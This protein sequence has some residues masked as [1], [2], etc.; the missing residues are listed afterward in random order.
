MTPLALTFPLVFAATA[1]G[2]RIALGWLRKRQI[3]DHPNERSSHRLPTPRG[4]GLAV[5]P[6]ILAAW[7][8]L[9][10]AGD[11]L[12]GQW[13]ATAAAVGLF[14]LSWQDDRV[15]LSARLRIAVHFAAAAV[16]LAWLPSDR[17]VF[18]GLLPLFADRAAALL[19]W[20][21]FI[22]LFNFM[23][24]IDG[25]SGVETA[26][27]GSGLVLVALGAPTLAAMAPLAAAAV[28]AGLGFLVWNWHPARI[29]LG[30]SGSVPLGYLLGWLLLVAAAHGAWA[31]ALI[32]PAYYLADATL[33][34]VKRAL[35]GQN[36][37]QA[38]RQHL[39]Q[40]AVQGGASHARVVRLILGVDCLLVG[41]ALI[42]GPH[43]IAALVAAA[44]VVA[45][46]LAGLARLGRGGA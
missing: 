38:H 9:A 14:V 17:L 2:T 16:G 18:Q 45:A 1:V 4:G 24:G 3:L 22:N 32:L 43:P 26:L 46:L 5:V 27:V 20:V 31:A 36:L 19:C 6:A 23:D 34:L 10:L 25:I 8:A 21:W 13:P 40:R 15:G 37:F 33:T 41:L 42:G 39:Y 7:V 44:V 12:P 28:A 30:D 11:A 29:F 35:T